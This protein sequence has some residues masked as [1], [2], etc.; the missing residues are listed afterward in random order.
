MSQP[1]APAHVAHLLPGFAIGTLAPDERRQT[2]A[3]LTGCPTCRAELAAWQ[4]IAS[5]L[6]EPLPNLPADDAPLHEVWRRVDAASQSGRRFRSN[7]RHGDG[8]AAGPTPV[9]SAP[10]RG[11]STG[12]AV[13]A[14]LAPAAQT[15]N[16]PPGVAPPRRPWGLLAITALLVLSLGLGYIALAPGRPDLGG[17]VRH[18][19]APAPAPGRGD[20]A[21]ET[22][23]DVVI[24]AAYVPAW[25]LA[26]IALALY[27]IP[28]ANTSTWDTPALRV[29]YVLAG[30]YRVHSDG[31]SMVI[32]RGATAPE[33]VP[34]GAELVLTS[35]DAFIAAAETTSEYATD[36]SAK[37][38]LLNW[39][40][41][42]ESDSR[43]VE[44]G[45]WLG[46]D[47]DHRRDLR[48][49]GGALSLRLLRIDLG[50]DAVLAA[51]DDPIQLI[52]RADFLESTIA[53][54]G[55]DARRN[56]GQTTATLYSST[57]SPT[58]TGPL[59]P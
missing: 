55:E 34:A 23:L 29:A 47:F 44:P 20:V 45:S 13:A 48:P 11:A 50:P 6:R 38:Q 37:A 32:R 30:E 10:R 49:P 39:M 16:A 54:T 26:S 7:H 3:H 40:L 4:T 59:M 22:L 42:E 41:V 56:I 51:P 14:A 1:I 18:L 46:H 57:V 52:V 36:A 28:P 12:P 53:M 9:A 33:D 24:P 8:H 35:G 21:Q 43:P 58:A 19:A 27:T 31:P 17:P 25:D 2:L 5:A 15:W